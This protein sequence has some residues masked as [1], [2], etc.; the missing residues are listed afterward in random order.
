MPLRA[1]DVQLAQAVLNELAEQYA[2]RGW[3]VNQ[4]VCL[5]A[6]CVLSGEQRRLR[7]HEPMLGQT[8]IPLDSAA[9]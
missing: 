6:W 3:E 8:T 5:A 9:S 1:E 4:H 2:Q 7:A